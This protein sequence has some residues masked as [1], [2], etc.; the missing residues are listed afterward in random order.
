MTSEAKTILYP[1]G[2]GGLAELLTSETRVTDAA[3]S[4]Q[5]AAKSGGWGAARLRQPSPRHSQA[6]SL[7]MFF[8]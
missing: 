6:T 4:L 2:L 3:P 5:F 1:E 7:T 8:A